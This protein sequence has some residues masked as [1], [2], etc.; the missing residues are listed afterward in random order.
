[1]ID[2]ASSWKQFKEITNKDVPSIAKMV[3]D[4]YGIKRKGFTISN[5][6]ANA[7]NERAHQTLGNIIRTFEMYKVYDILTEQHD[8]P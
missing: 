5:P 7:I 3:R 6:E 2:P 8:N 4:D 1:M